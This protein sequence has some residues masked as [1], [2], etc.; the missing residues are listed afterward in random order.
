MYFRHFSS[1][2]VCFF[3][4]WRADVTSDLVSWFSSR[5]SCTPAS[6][7]TLTTHIHTLMM[8][9]VPDVG[10]WQLIVW[11]ESLTL[12]P[13]WPAAP[14]GPDGPWETHYNHM[15]AHAYTYICAFI[16]VFVESCFQWP[17]SPFLLECRQDLENH[18]HPERKP[19]QDQQLFFHTTETFIHS[20]SARVPLTFRPWR[21]G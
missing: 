1:F 11:S 10:R 3:V 7:S 17:S 20:S 4:C 21:P 9:D 13:L 5:S 16:I 6:T 15:S 18:Q 14:A 8:L 2:V 12:G 19:P